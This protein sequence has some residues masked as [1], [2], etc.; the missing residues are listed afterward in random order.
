MDEIMTQEGLPHEFHVTPN[1]GHW[2]PDYLAER[3][4]QAITHIRG[5]N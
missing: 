3:I 1:I 5:G 4:D 2:Y